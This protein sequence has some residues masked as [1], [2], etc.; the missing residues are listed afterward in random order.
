M[1]PT[2]T[3]KNLDTKLGRINLTGPKICLLLYLAFRYLKTLF[4]LDILSL[5]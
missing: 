3:G 2:V 1:E 5:L 4:E